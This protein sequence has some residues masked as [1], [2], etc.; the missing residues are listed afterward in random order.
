MNVCQ[1][2]ILFGIVMILYILSVSQTNATIAI[3]IASLVVISFCIQYL[4]NNE[5]FGIAWLISLIP[6]IYILSIYIML[7]LINDI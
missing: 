3:R 4:C 1:P 7:Y 2:V 5:F 6:I